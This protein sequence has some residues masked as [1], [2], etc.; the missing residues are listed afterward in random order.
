MMHSS[1][2]P[3]SFPTYAESKHGHNHVYEEWRSN[4]AR[5]RDSFSYRC[6][7]KV[8]IRCWLAWGQ[9]SLSRSQMCHFQSAASASWGQRDALLRRKHKSRLKVCRSEL[10]RQALSMLITRLIRKVPISIL[11][12]NR[13][14]CVTQIINQN[15]S[16]ARHL[17][18]GAVDDDRTPIMI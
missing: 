15:S 13:G 6:R 14:N 5:L 17:C 3:F 10:Q 8:T 12:N 7:Q 1:A 18:R 4:K 2:K 11:W 9:R 16:N